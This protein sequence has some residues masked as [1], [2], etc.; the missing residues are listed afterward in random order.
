MF[1][2]V[3]IA[4]ILYRWL[5]FEMT[6]AMLAPPY[7]I[8]MGAVAIATLAGA[9]LLLYAQGHPGVL[10]FQPFITALTTGFWAAATWW[11]PLLALLTAWRH[12]AGK[13]SLAYDP[14]YWSMVFPLGMYT[15]AT[16]TFARAASHDFLLPIPR[17]FVWVAIT[18]WL[19]AFA[20]LLLRAG[21][22]AMAARR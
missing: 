9:D 13:I 19:V 16:A 15:A 8:N 2:A 21:H 20:G 1:Y 14:Q 4:L 5:F 22:A 6:P 18:A 3:L 17:L 11:V 10:G 7:W 12:V